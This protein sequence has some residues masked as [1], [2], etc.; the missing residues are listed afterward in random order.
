MPLKLLQ[1]FCHPVILI[2]FIILLL[3]VLLSY[4]LYDSV[5]GYTLLLGM[6]EYKTLVMRGDMDSA[7][8]TLLS[9]PKEHHNRCACVSC[10]KA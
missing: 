1:I 7:N 3:M 4:S 9:I 8:N 6:I 2:F 5:M 10:W